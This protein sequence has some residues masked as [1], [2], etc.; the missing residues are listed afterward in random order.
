MILLYLLF[1]ESAEY[2]SLFTFKSK[3]LTKIKKPNIF[4]LFRPEKIKNLD[5]LRN[6]S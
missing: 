5:Y 1:F 6:I 3:E 2:R 4:G